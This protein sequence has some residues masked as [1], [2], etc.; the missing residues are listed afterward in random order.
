[1]PFDGRSLRLTLVL[2]ASQQLALKARGRVVCVAIGHWQSCNPAAVQRRLC[3]CSMDTQVTLKTER[4]HGLL[5]GRLPAGRL[6]RVATLEARPG[7][8]TRAAADG[9]VPIECY[10]FADYDAVSLIT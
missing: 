10:I 8:C 1:V 5:S 2:A 6:I 7:R 3:D 9:E 4:P